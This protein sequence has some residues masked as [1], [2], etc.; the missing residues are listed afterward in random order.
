M[1]KKSNIVITALLCLIILNSCDTL[2]PIT[3]PENDDDNTSPG[4]SLSISH[5]GNVDNGAIQG[6]HVEVPI[7]L[8]T[9]TII[10][11]FDLL[12]GYDAS[13]L[14]FQSASPGNDLTDNGWEY[15]TYRYGNNGIN[16][17]STCPSGLIRFIAIAETNNGPNYATQ[18]IVSDLITIDFL[19]TNNRS[20]ECQNIPLRFFWADCGDNA[21][22]NWGRITTTLFIS[23]KV[24]DHPLDSVGI[25]DPDVG[26]TTYL[27]AQ[28]IDCD[29]SRYDDSRREISFYNGSVQIACADSIRCS[30][31]DINLNDIA[32]EI[33]DA[34]LLSNY[35]VYGMQVFMGDT[36]CQIAAS[37]INADDIPL[38]VADFVYLVRII[39]GDAMPHPALTPITANFSQHGNILSI[40]KNMGAVQVVVTG[41]ATYEL[42]A[43]NMYIKSKYDGTNTTLFIYSFEG[44]IFTGDFLSTSGE[45]VSIEFGSANGAMVDITPLQL[46]LEQNYPNPF[47]DSTLIPFNINITADVTLTV[48]NY[49]ERQVLEETKEFNSGDNIF[50]FH[51]NRL[52]PGQ[53]KYTLTAN[54]FK[55]SKT[56]MIV[57]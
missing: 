50:I 45:I 34:V 7:T 47:I 21:L 57:R 53:Y 43:D 4:F 22:V 32:N 36:T 2:N 20:L 24:Y 41:D 38:T 8:S 29:S 6:Q 17:D 54:E 46:T 37:D 31:G 56:M 49:L 35:F 28:D 15:F 18:A 26:Y 52:H 27:G 23:D 51:A 9:D 16:C 33:A 10:G 19:V 48:E 13:A 3:Q 11:G 30:R 55:T 40:D 5:V 25:Q 12:I 14:S 1:Y 39:I 42:L 44:N